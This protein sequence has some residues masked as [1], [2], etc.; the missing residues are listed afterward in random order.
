[1]GTPIARPTDDPGVVPTGVLGRV[2]ARVFHFFVDEE[3]A[4]LLRVFPL[5]QLQ[6]ASSCLC[7]LLTCLSSTAQTGWF[8]LVEDV[9]GSE[10]DVRDREGRG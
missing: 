3:V 10:R 7:Q 5:P 6:V 9:A 2:P 1:M 8:R 4:V